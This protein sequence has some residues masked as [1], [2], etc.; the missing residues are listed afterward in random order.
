[1]VFTFVNIKGVHKINPVHLLIHIYYMNVYSADVNLWQGERE[2]GGVGV[3][4][5]GLVQWDRRKQTRERK[6][7]GGGGGFS[8]NHSR[9][10]F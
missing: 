1:M 10:S 9:P 2:R 5:S 8:R 3:E 4:R 6:G 7:G